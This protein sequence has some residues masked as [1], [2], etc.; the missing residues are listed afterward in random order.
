ME[1]KPIRKR[2]EGF[3]WVRSG[4]TL[5]FGP[6]FDRGLKKMFEDIKNLTKK[7]GE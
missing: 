4:E 1:E 7:K 5:T 3:S 2:T 6:Q